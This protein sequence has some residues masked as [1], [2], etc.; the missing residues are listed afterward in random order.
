MFLIE[1]YTTDEKLDFPPESLIDVFEG[2][3]IIW[4]GP[5]PY[6]GQLPTNKFPNGV[7]ILTG[8]EG[9]DFWKEKVA[10][11]H[12]RHPNVGADRKPSDPGTFEIAENTA[13]DTVVGT[14][15]NMVD[16]DVSDSYT[17]SLVK[18]RRQW[19]PTI[20]TAIPAVGLSGLLAGRHYVG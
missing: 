6:P 5:G 18:P 9:L 10:D 19:P 3:T 15:V 16:P 4:L 20:G 11:W 13:A 7:Q 2:N 12:N 8:Q 1:H 17:F 14:L